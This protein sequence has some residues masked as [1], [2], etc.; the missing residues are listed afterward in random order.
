LF[1]FVVTSPCGAEQINI[2]VASNA[3]AAVKLISTEFGKKTGHI[4]KIS[5]GSTGKLYTQIVNGAPFDIFLAANEREPEKLEQSHLIVPNTRFTYALGKLVAWSID[6]QLLKDGNIKTILNSSAVMR[7][8]IANPKIAPY[9]F[10]A[11]QALENL[12]IWNSLQAKIIRGENVSQCY[13]FAM[14]NNA[15]VG[16]VAKS[17][18]LNNTHA[19]GSYQELPGELYAP[20]RQQAVLLMRSKHKSVGNQFIEFMK[21]DAVREILVTK[22]GYGV[23]ANKGG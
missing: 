14:T 10:A 4:L 12:G 2:A 8:A 11:Q 19:S 9:G 5:S 21:S 7:I 17:Q 20:I 22:F 6:D 16:F 1:Y 15:Q 23:E 18:I 3:L 13:Q